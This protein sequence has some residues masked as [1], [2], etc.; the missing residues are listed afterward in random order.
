M[1]IAVAM[2]TVAIIVPRIAGVIAKTIGQTRTIKEVRPVSNRIAPA[3]NHT[4]TMHTGR[5]KAIKLCEV[6][7][8]SS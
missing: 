7:N 1:F 2:H 4:W 5:F 3:T 6:T 8:E